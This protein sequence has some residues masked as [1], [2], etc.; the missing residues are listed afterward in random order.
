[1]NYS[2]WATHKLIHSGDLFFLLIRHLRG[3]ERPKL[4]PSIDHFKAKLRARGVFL[5]FY[6]FFRMILYGK[7]LL[8]E[9]NSSSEAFMIN[10]NLAP[11]PME[12][13]VMRSYLKG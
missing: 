9:L 1:M 3:R 4:I 6:Y 2:I 11:R 8:F 7:S 5:F 10:S 12:I 13:T